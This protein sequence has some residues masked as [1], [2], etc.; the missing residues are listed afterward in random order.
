[1]QQ[2]RRIKLVL[3]LAITVLAFVMVAYLTLPAQRFARI[4]GTM[5]ESFVESCN[6]LLQ[7]TIPEGATSV[8]V[9][10]ERAQI[11]SEIRRF[12]PRRIVVSSNRVWMMFGGGKVTGFSVYWAPDKNDPTEW[13][14]TLFDGVRERIL[15]RRSNPRR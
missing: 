2:P 10:V 11:P 9:P 12:A 4:H 6:R 5:L 8:E 1:M 3:G 7:V 15:L 14:L 13:T